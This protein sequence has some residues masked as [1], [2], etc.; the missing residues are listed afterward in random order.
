MTFN[1]E[2]KQIH[3]EV[4]ALK[5][6]RG[7][8]YNK[9]LR[10]RVLNWMDDAR[11]EGW[12]D[13]EASH[14]IGVPLARIENWRMAD[15]ERAA[16]VVPEAVV[17]RATSETALMPVVIRDCELPFGSSI[18]FTTPSGYRVDGLSL[19]QALGLL[20]AYA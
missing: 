13:L 6:G 8:K 20:R 11:E 9:A 5:P 12:F 17:P 7:R 4:A 3:A 16:T 2:T 1:E 18:S 19:D 15:R 14:K 10:E